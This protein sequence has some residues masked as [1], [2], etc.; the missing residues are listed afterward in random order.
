MA[1]L[2]KQDIIEVLIKR[3]CENKNV[4]YSIRKNYFT[5][6][7]M[8]IPNYYERFVQCAE[9]IFAIN[10]HNESDALSEI[11]KYFGINKNIN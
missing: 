1:S 10:G 5:G 3:V 6:I 2:S 7:Y 4:D 8:H 9:N 11:E